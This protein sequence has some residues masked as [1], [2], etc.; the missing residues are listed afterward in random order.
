MSCRTYL[1]SASQCQPLLRNCH[2]EIGFKVQLNLFLRLL[3]QL[4]ISD[5]VLE[6]LY[7][8]LADRRPPF[9]APEAGRCAH[10]GRKQTAKVEAAQH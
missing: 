8:P 3:L 5:H 2:E 7:M 6:L 4:I 9:L 10:N 1:G